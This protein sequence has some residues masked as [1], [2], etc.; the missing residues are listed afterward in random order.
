[1]SLA[2]GVCVRWL[3][4]C[5]SGD[6]LPPHPGSHPPVRPPKALYRFP[7]GSR[8]GEGFSG[9]FRKSVA[10]SDPVIV[11]A[12][13]AGRPRPPN[14]AL[15]RR[16]FVYILRIAASACQLVPDT[17]VR[18]PCSERSSA[19]SPCGQVNETSSP[20]QPLIMR[21]KISNGTPSRTPAP[22]LFRRRASVNLRRRNIFNGLLL[23]PVK[24][25]IPALNS[26]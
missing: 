12:I 8:K 24:E 19:I 7:A 26:I 13:A 18:I 14:P 25:K 21:G 9:I 6:A 17:F 1:M 2:S 4:L 3:S 22:Q 10:P 11:S 23:V 20:L 5:H 16:L 15:A